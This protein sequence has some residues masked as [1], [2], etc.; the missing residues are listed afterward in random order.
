M[1]VSGINNGMVNTAIENAKRDVKNNE[2][3]K[4][5]KKAYDQKDKEKLK[6]ACKD[7]EQ[8][9][10]GIMYKQMRATVPKSSLIE[11]SFARETFEEMLD[12]RIAQEAA[13]GQGIGLA[14]V[15]Y[16]SLVKDMEATYT[17]EEGNCNGEKKTD[18]QQEEIE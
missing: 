11:G 10:L 1:D 4:L 16:K 6:K 7:F 15:L 18:I 5:L 17:K 9:F 3:E 2:F 8:I 12:E 13:K 14:D